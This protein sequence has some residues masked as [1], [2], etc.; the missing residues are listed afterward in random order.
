MA[1]FSGESRGTPLV[2][3]EM[4][5]AMRRRLGE[6]IGVCWSALAIALAMLLFSYDAN[7]P[8]H[9]S[10]TPAPPSNWLGRIGA[11]VAD[12]L[13]RSMGI[14]SWGL[15]WFLGVWG[16]RFL[17]HRGEGRLTR[18]APMLVPATVLGMVFA[19]THAPWDSWQLASGPGLGGFVGDTVV[20]SLIGLLPLPPNQV[21]QLLSLGTGIGTAIFA[22]AALG[23]TRPEAVSILRWLWASLAIVL[24]QVSHSVR[25]RTA[26]AI[27]RWRAARAVPRSERMAPAKPTG[28]WKE[29]IEKMRS[30]SDP[31][32]FS[33]AALA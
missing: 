12:P 7:D 5:E 4:S 20:V 33:K 19:S 13:M 30:R 32:V 11:I 26:A 18:R 21:L 17:L 15:V 25:I 22:G 3:S 10:A 24:Y 29:R 23:V 6:V 31:P 14:A 27:A 8:S 9:F 2:D 28:S 1:F 16:I